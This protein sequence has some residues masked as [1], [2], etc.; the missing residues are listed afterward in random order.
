MKNWKKIAL[1]ISGIGLMS[2][3]LFTVSAAWFQGMNKA[4]LSSGEGYTASAYFAGGDGSSANPYII[5]QPIHLYN[6]AW[7][8]YLGYFNQTKDGAYDQ[9]Y[10]VLG[11]DVDM[12]S[13]STNNWTL[14][15]IGTTDNPFIGNFDGKGYTISNLVV[16]NSLSDGHITRKPSTVSSITG[17][18]IVG[19]FGVVGN[20]NLSSSYTYNSAVNT[21]MDFKLNKTEVKSSLSSTLI[22]VA[23][24][25]VNAAITNV[26]IL[27]SKVTVSSGSSALSGGPTTNL[28][29]YST[30]GYCTDAYKTTRSINA[31]TIKAPTTSISHFTA[32]ESGDASGWGGSI[33]M[34]TM[35]NRLLSFHQNSTKILDTSTMVLSETVTVEADGTST[36]SNT[37]YYASDSE[38]SYREYYDSANPL[39]GSYCFGRQFSYS[40][41]EMTTYLYLN[42][43][44]TFPKTTTKTT[45]SNNLYAIAYGSTYLIP[46]GTTAL[47]ATTSSTNAY[48][49]TFSSIATGSSYANSTVSTTISGT[50]Y[51]L[52]L[53]TTNNGTATL[54]T[55]SQTLRVYTT[56]SVPYRIAARLNGSSY[57]LRY[58]TSRTWYV[59]TSTANLTIG[60]NGT[61]ETIVTQNEATY[62]TY[63]PLNVG[64]DSTDTATYQLPTASNTGYVVS[65]AQYTSGT[66]YGYGNIRVSQY[67]MSNLSVAL[68]SSTYNSN[69]SN[70]EVVT[71]TEGSGGFVRV[72]DSYNSSNTASS[73][74]SSTYGTKTNYSTLGLQKYK[75]SR[76]SLHTVFTA[77]SSYVYGLHFLDADISINDLATASAA[78]VRKTDY[79]NY[80]MP[81]NSIDFNLQERGYINFFSGSYYSGNDS[82]FSLHQITR[83]STTSAI[84]SIKEISKVYGTS[85]PSN[86]YIYLYT[87]GTYS[88]SLTSAY[89]EV[90]DT[91]WIM[92]P[93]IVSDAMYY[94]EI[95]V[96]AGEYA[97]GSVSNG[98][99]AYLI[100]LDISANAQEVNRTAVTE[101]I[102]MVNNV[103]EYPL[104][105]SLIALSTDTIDP[106]TGVAV[107]LTSS[108]TGSLNLSKADSTITITSSSDAFSPGW[109]GDAIT[110]A[111]SGSSDPPSVVPK[112]TSTSTI[113]RLTYIDYNTTTE[114]TTSTIITDTNGTMTYTDGNGTAITS[115]TDSTGK[116]VETSSV[117]SVD[118]SG[119]TTDICQYWYS[120]SAASSTI[121]ATFVFTHVQDTS[122]TTYHVDKVTGYT[123]TIASTSETLNVHI[124]AVDG[125]YIITINGT[126]IT[127]GM[128]PIVVNPA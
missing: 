53:P 110:L 17:V 3:S 84:S 77:N 79:T 105:V 128:S 98:T 81:R 73:T 52:S 101:Y 95:P 124:T 1:A 63:F 42:G 48:I 54:S 112:S 40:G 123:I 37:Q 24:G 30:I 102:L 104:G 83:D 9:T 111:R 41:S 26:G 23:A 103:Y 118:V 43:Y 60:R 32:P 100:Y 10:F 127:V 31:T 75:K 90:F 64:T 28:S 76:E 20:Y 96:N 13:D 47:S 69:G 94:F 14:P 70:L 106:L 50:T 59:T 2:A 97:L 116:T 25:Y 109:K 45:Y 122:N 18:N 119:L 71:R 39:K 55:T 51:Y 33:D 120:Y 11:S 125:G 22:G 126:T 86:P 67:A 99:G 6:L 78:R 117:T 87:D 36:T 16:D 4:A 113:K 58:S 121:T 80:Q 34:N 72:S 29:D 114:V 107:A 46:N 57:Y 5:N 92:S 44:R 115:F 56:N 7:L 21:I 88:A 49:W 35:Y 12:T 8:Q 108:Y 68:N 85:S 91:A 15:P 66:N 93:T 89:S 19:T 62:D 74:L 38:Y 82:F 27:D 65:G 61:T